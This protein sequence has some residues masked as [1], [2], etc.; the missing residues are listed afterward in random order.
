M[1][2]GRFLFVMSAD[3]GASKREK[4]FSTLIGPFTSDRS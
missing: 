1:R 3:E 2:D 4:I